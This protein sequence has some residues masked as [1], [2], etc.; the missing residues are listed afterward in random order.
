M[1][2]EIVYV[3]PTGVGYHPVLYMVK[4]A[5]ELFDATLTILYRQDL[6]ML[7]KA[8]GLIP[9][10]RTGQ[11]CLLIAP[12]PASLVHLSQIEGWR[13][14]Y[15]RIVAW[16]FDSFWVDHIPRFARATDHFDH[17]F[18]TEK[19]DL[20][21]WRETLRGPVTWLPWGADALNL[22]SDNPDRSI[23]VFRIG[24]QPPAWEDDE[25]SARACAERG[26]RF[27]GRP[28]N[29]DDAVDNQQALMAIFRQAKFTLSFSNAVSP[30]GYTHPKRQYIT[31]RWTDALASGAVVAGIP[32]AGE[33]TSDL[34]WDEALLDLGTVDRTAGAD[35]IA[36]AVRAWTPDR[37]R[38]N[39]RRSLER[40]DWRLRFQE[41]KKALGVSA[42]RLDAELARLQQRIASSAVP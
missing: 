26:L 32:P 10:T 28:P 11:P 17:V 38:I 13:T 35:I 39:H 5:V 31:A 20:T 9:R 41:L 3:D 37:A 8:A 4:L 22:G 6:N 1:A 42:P 23:D 29:H 34:L 24:R 16:V 30:A 21:T 27:Q 18:V 2:L 12:S 40:L 14:R 33:S 36:Q 7:Q 25:V 15:G 19:E